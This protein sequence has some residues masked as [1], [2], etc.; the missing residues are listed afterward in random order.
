MTRTL[1]P[2]KYK[3]IKPLC[4]AVCL[5]LTKLNKHL[6]CGLAI[7]PLLG[8]YPKEIKICSRKDFYTKVHSSSE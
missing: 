4:K 7:I 5:V 3:M 2:W 6:P 8:V 1:I